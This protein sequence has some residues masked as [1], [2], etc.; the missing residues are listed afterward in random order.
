MNIYIVSDASSRA[1]VYGIGT[2]LRELTRSLRKYALNTTVIHIFSDKPD[3]DRI[4]HEGV[5]HL[6]IPSY[7]KNRR[8]KD[9]EQYN[10]LYQQNVVYFLRQHIPQNTEKLVFQLNFNHCQKMAD[11]LKVAFNCK[12][13]WVGHYL[14]WGLSLH[15]SIS[16]LQSILSKPVDDRNNAEQAICSAFDM[17]QTLAKTVDHTISLSKYMKKLFCNE[18]SIDSKQISVVPNGLTDSYKNFSINKNLLR[19]KW[20]IDIDEN[21]ILFAGRLDIIK[22][23]DY[24]I[25][26]FREVLKVI[27]KCRLLVVG[28]GPYNIYIKESIDVFAKISYSGLIP[29]ENL[30]ELYHIADIG[31]VPSLYEPFGYVAVEMMMHGLPMITTATSGLN[32][33]V[34]DGISALK[35]P[36]QFGVKNEE[37]D[38]MQLARKIVFLLQNQDVANH[39]KKN[40]RKRYEKLYTSKKMGQSMFNLYKSLFR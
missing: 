9:D 38:I 23:L 24:L 40:A 11:R 32:E 4:E 39:L 7:K 30:F 2:Y 3:L 34:E 1:N 15:G 36:V 22:G 16:L 25:K 12:L 10:N 19:T 8:D 33:L 27:P 5:L 37:I 13:I 35:I 6:Y 18:Y 28:D 20:Q 14:E 31:V 21:L 17:E 26:A 29:R